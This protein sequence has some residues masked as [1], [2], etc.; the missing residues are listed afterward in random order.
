MVHWECQYNETIDDVVLAYI[1]THGQ[2]RCLMHVVCVER[3]ANIMSKNDSN[4]FLWTPNV[5]M[6]CL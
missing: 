2:G 1:D 3:G 4:F 6:V 5:L